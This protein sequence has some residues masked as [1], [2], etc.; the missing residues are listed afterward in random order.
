MRVRAWTARSATLGRGR[1][2]GPRTRGARVSRCSQCC[3]L[4]LLLFHR[5]RL[6]GACGAGCGE[7]TPGPRGP[8]RIGR[9]PASR[10][11]PRSSPSRNL[12]RGRLRPL[13][14]FRL[15]LLPL[16]HRHAPLNRLVLNF[17]QGLPVLRV[18]LC[19]CH[20]LSIRPLFRRTR[21]CRTRAARNRPRR[22]QFSRSTG[23]ASSGPSAAGLLVRGPPVKSSRSG[24]RGRF[25]SGTA[26]RPIRWSSR[27][28]WQ[29]AIRA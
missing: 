21:V 22:Q 13:R 25:V 27:W 12:S 19:P 10:T 24:L 4:D 15:H 2:P 28:F 6:F 26:E 14:V 16:L 5:S 29:V 8:C 1:R 11:G 7:A 9:R 23:A 17:A 20:D 3:L 18:G